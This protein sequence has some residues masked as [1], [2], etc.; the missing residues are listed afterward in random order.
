PASHWQ[1][2]ERDALLDDVMTQQGL[3]TV[4]IL[5]Q[6]GGDVDAFLNERT[7]FTA[8]WRQIIL[9]TQQGS[10]QDFSMY[11]MACRKLAD[12]GRFH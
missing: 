3:L 11:A 4:D 9:N 2:M 12:L 7:Q 8:D 6:T 10:Q 1:S 5:T